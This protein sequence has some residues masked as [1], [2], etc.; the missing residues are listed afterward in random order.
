MVRLT[1]LPSCDQ[2]KM[3]GERTAACAA[4]THP[5]LVSGIDRGVHRERAYLVTEWV[6]GPTV[7]DLVDRYSCIAEGPALGIARD[8]LRGLDFA[9]RAGL[10]HGQITPEDILVPDE[11]AVKLKGIGPDLSD[12]GAANDYRSPEQREGGRADPRSDIF[13]LGAVL[14]EMLSGRAPA[15]EGEAAPPLRHIRHGLGT[16]TYELVNRMT[17]PDPEDR[18]A[19]HD[20][21]LEAIE[22]RLEQ[23]RRRVQFNSKPKHSRSGRKRAA[24]RRRR[25]AG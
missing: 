9:A 18:F 17:S 14:Y 15:E 22:E 4:I 5:N 12:S 16:D 24:S 13:A 1:I 11:A 8:V 21:A 3:L 10:V 20:E 7:R 6:E 25:H 19:D 23:L 2:P